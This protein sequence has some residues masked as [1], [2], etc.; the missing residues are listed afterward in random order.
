MKIS[1]RK[2]LT[3]ALLGL[4]SLFMA[5]QSQA[6]TE[7]QVGELDTL[8]DSTLLPNSGDQEEL[9]YIA[10]VVGT[11]VYLVDKVDYSD[12]STDP[13]YVGDFVLAVTDDNIA[14]SYAI[15]IDDATD[16]YLIKIGC[17]TGCTADTYLFENL[18]DLSYAY[19]TLSSLN[20]SEILTISHITT[21][22]PV[23]VPAALW[24]FGSAMIGLVG[25]ARRRV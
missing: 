20:I 22:A 3:L 17:G 9:D 8:L 23:P 14:D 2:N 10:S 21:A 16:Y 13:D 24:L 7:S 6:L 4:C 19:F 18:E 5:G 15:A 25:V 11:D 1:L 12:V